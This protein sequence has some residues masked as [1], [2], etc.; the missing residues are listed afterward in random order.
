MVAPRADITMRITTARPVPLLFF[1][2]LLFLVPANGQV[3]VPRLVTTLSAD[4]TQYGQHKIPI[5]KAGI[6]FSRIYW[7]GEPK[8]P[9][10]GTTSARF[11]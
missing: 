2:F 9:W 1:L 7:S 3:A 10:P 5:W 6:F 8:S 11:S 4:Q